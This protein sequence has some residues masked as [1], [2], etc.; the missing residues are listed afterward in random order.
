MGAGM[1]LMVDFASVELGLI[2][3]FSLPDEQGVSLACE[4][5][6]AAVSMA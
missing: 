1:K 5:G 2:L 4:K 3:S 6:S